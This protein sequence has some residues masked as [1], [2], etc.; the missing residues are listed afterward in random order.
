M[1]GFIQ[2]LQ[3]FGVTAKHCTVSYRQLFHSRL[4]QPINTIK[5]DGEPGGELSCLAH[6]IGAGGA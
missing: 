3:K 1:E 5:P 4:G 6:T 2:L